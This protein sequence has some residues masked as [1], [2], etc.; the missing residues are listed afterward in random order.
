MADRTRKLVC[1]AGTVIQIY[2]RPNKTSLEPSLCHRIVTVEE[3]AVRGL[4]VT[5]KWI[6]AAV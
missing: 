6:S 1:I 2:D 4:T 5:M 3:N